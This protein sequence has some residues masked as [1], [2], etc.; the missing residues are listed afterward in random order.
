MQIPFAR[1]TSR[2]QDTWLDEISRPDPIC[3][4]QQPHHDLSLGCAEG[5]ALDDFGGDDPEFRPSQ[6][7]ISEIAWGGQTGRG[8][9]KNC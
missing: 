8:A 6:V 2:A 4:P 1:F 7:E 9:A 3:E 5:V